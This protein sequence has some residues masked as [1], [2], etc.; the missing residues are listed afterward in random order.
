MGQAQEP[1]L[2]KHQKPMPLT[3]IH[4]HNLLLHFLISQMQDLNTCPQLADLFWYCCQ[5]P[6]KHAVGF[7]LPE[8]KQLMVQNCMQLFIPLFR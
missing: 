8:L 5:T 6:H 3:A 1:K 2:A 7:W 4:A